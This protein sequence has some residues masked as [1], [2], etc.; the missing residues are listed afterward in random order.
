MTR[1]LTVSSKFIHAPA[2]HTAG[3]INVNAAD[4]TNAL[5]LIGNAGANILTG[6]AQADIIDGKAGIDI[7]DG[8]NN[9]DVYFISVASQHTAAEINDTGISGTDEVRF[10]TKSASTLTLYAGDTGLERIVIGTGDMVNAVTTA[11]T[12]ANIN[13]AAVTNGLTLIGN[14][15]ANILTGTA[16]N[17]TFSGN[18]GNDTITGGSGADKLI[19]VY[20]FTTH[21]IYNLSRVRHCR[22]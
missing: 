7:L 22:D 16:F 4:V 14:N 5:T 19:T 3:S 8:R 20:Y 17:D 18:N 2:S 15:G 6:T 21:W 13:A 11:K 10:A 1:S 12:A 9:S